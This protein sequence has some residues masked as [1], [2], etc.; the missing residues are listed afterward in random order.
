MIQAGLAG[1]TD[2]QQLYNRYYWFLRF[3][4]LTKARTGCN[5]G[6][7][8]QAFKLLDGAGCQVDWAIIESVTKRVQQEVK[9]IVIE[10]GSE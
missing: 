10:G 8:Q 4:E 9:D 1:L 3:A 2:E 5:A 7:D 6:L